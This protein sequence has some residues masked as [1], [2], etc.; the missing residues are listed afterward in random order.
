MA[1]TTNTILLVML[2][3]LAFFFS[4]FSDA[5]IISF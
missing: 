2:G 1:T 3:V 4:V 5:D